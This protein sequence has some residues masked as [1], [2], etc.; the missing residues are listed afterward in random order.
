MATSVLSTPDSQSILNFAQTFYV[1]PN[2]VGQ[3]TSTQI[4]SI[5]LYFMYKPQ[6]VGNQSGGNYPGITIYISDTI[7]GVPQINAN[8]YNNS[9][10]AEWTSILTSSDAS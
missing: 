2:L 6:A 10:R 3:Q 9:A 4:T 8:T 7:F 1:D 5:Q